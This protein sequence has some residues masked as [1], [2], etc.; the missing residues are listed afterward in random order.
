MFQRRSLSELEMW[1]DLWGLWPST[2]TNDDKLL[3]E[4]NTHP[5]IQITY[6]PNY[7][8]TYLLTPC[9]RV[10]LEKLT[11][12]QLV[13]KVSTFYGTQRFITAFTSACL[14]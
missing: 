12:L 5:H 14:S 11:G 4:I 2:A 10:L 8:L 9:S 13:K 6:L 7:L 1:G 3:K